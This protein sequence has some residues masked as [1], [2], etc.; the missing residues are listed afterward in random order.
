MP[1]K[2]NGAWFV[3]FRMGRGGLMCKYGLGKGV[4]HQTIPRLEAMKH[5][6]RH[7][8][9][10]PHGIHPVPQISNKFDLES[11]DSEH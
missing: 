10:P 1:T 6:S 3:I 5:P 4:Y 8:H 9:D 7:G 11:V 2:R